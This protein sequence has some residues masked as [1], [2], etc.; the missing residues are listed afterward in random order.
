[1]RAPARLWP[2]AVLLAAAGA[3]LP[4]AAAAD[5]GFGFKNFSVSFAK[6]GG[7]EAT[8]AGSHPY[9]Q[10]VSFDLNTKLV[11]G[12]EVPINAVKDLKVEL[13]PGFTGNPF[14][15]KPCSNAELLEIVDARSSCPDSAAIGIVD[16]RVGSTSPGDKFSPV[17]NLS[18]PPGVAAR[19][20]FVVPEGSGVPFTI[21]LSVNPNPPY[22]LIAFPKDVPQPLRVYGSTLTVW[23]VPGDPAHDP[24]RGNCLR[25][26]GTL[27]GKECKGGAERPFLL[28]PRSCTGTLTTTLTADPWQEPGAWLDPPLA[29]QSPAMQDC[30][31]LHFGPEISARPTNHAAESPTGLDFGLDVKD[32]G[33]ENPKGR[34][35]SDI[36]KAVVTLPEGMTVNPSQAEGLGVCSEDALKGETAFSGPGE[37]CPQSSKIGT[38]EV[39]T[40]LLEGQILRGGLFVASPYTNRF[41]TLLALYMTIKDPELGVNVILAGRVEPDPKTGQLVTTFDDLPQQPFSHFRLHFREGGRSPLVTPPLC[42][43]YTTTALFYPWA[44]PTSPFETTSSFK[45]E[46]GPGGGPCPA[47]GN[48]PFSPGFVAGTIDNGA[49]RYSPFYMQLT[50]HDG[51][52]DLTRFS[53]ILPPG[54]VG[55]IVGVSKCPQ[56]LVEVAKTLTGPHGGAEELAHPSCPSSSLIGHTLS[57]AG[58]G[59]ELTYVPGFL[60]LGGSYHGDP[61]SVI[62]IT[63]A[64][65]GP[66][67]AGTVVVQ[68]A[69]KLNPVTAEVE[70]DGSASDPIPHILKGI[71]LKVRE[72][73]VLTDR[74][75]FTLNPTSCEAEVTRATLWGGG[76]N[77]FSTAD[78]LPFARTAPFQAANCAR[79]GFKPKLAIKLKGGTK[80]GGHPALKAIV[81]PRTQD[82]NFAGAVVTLPHSAFLDQAH[83][84][85]ICTRVQFSAGVGNGANCPAGAI[86]GH[87]KA[88]SPLL[89]EPLKG[90]VFLRSS[91]HNLPDLVVALHGIVDITLDSRIDSIHGGIRSSFE[92]VPDAPVSRFIL[93]MQGAK[94]GLIVNSTNLCGA[95]HRANAE[96][97]AQNGAKLQTHPALGASCPK[98]ARRHTRR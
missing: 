73:R 16:T 80:R 81:T 25:P 6:E 84:R 57:G 83:I 14:A 51:N 34:A 46:S 68:E 17:Y 63:P 39:E 59:P 3:L 24:E 44:N 19:I 62:A 38:V 75:Q 56:A 40:P 85:T 76:A 37:G 87:A 60:Y 70:V 97:D 64:V 9:S 42:G 66:F 10:S 54:V 90:P 45:V 32:E 11:T 61:L 4:A 15:V 31:A 71:P 74:P 69:L 41:G 1:M 35:L 72:I 65:A 52:Q 58:V 48:P 79:L 77:V 86:Y 88:W 13:P 49:G 2:Y 98:D 82:A 55:K 28:M 33:I 18:P 27:S 96:L 21:E 89:D 91:S 8:E 94:K 26:D 93:E 29:A 22:N 78:D 7:A 67:D 23:G 36:K 30:A 12:G 47:G 20:G 50:R 53:S 92:A 43:T 95:A 5:E